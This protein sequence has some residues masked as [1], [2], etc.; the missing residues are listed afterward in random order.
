MRE[1]Q[2]PPQCIVESC[3][4]T[5]A[6]GEVMCPG[7]VKAHAANGTA[8]TTA[9]TEPDDPDLLERTA[10]QAALQEAEEYRERRRVKRWE[11]KDNG[12]RTPVEWFTDEELV[13]I[14]AAAQTMVRDLDQRLSQMP[15]PEPNRYASKVTMGQY[16]WDFDPQT[17]EHIKEDPVKAATKALK[18]ALKGK[19]GPA[20]QK[21]AWALA[22][23]LTPQSP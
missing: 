16:S 3:P 15:Q 8:T 17:G 20:A 1:G 18:Q 11:T 4:R 9:V 14:D 10:R 6:P 21:M 2:Q 12:T 19:H 13:A 23:S 7:H 5:P 22:E